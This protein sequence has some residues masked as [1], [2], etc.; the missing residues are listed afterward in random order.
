[1]RLVHSEYVPMLAQ[2][3]GEGVYR[4]AMLLASVW[5]H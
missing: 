1:M 2:G 5:M 3:G 4:L